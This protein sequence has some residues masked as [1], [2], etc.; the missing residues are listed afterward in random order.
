MGFW[1]KIK[2]GLKKGFEKVGGF[3]KK[4]ATSVYNVAKGAEKK[5]EGAI[6]T[7]YNDAKALTNKVIDKESEFAN[8]I[9]NKGADVIKK[10][11]DTIGGIASS[12]SMP[13][14]IGGCAVLAFLVLKK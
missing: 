2:N 14:I 7:V 5:V 8:N 12:L 6:T 9:V 4:A 10:G 13:L 11:E 1:S 3:I